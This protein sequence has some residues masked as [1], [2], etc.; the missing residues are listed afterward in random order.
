M[1]HVRH[2]TARIAHMNVDIL[3]GYIGLRDG[4]SLFNHP[5]QFS[6]H[7][8]TGFVRRIPNNEGWTFTDSDD[9][10]CKI[11][12]ASDT[13]TAIVV[14]DESSTDPRVMDVIYAM[15]DIIHQL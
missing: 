3:R 11:V 13:R 4:Q 10:K 8:T 5:M 14:C 1:E 9:V 6:V 7:R 2:R 12:I 15:D